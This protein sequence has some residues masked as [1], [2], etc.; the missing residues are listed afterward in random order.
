[1]P[2]HQLGGRGVSGTRHWLSPPLRGPVYSL[3][4]GSTPFL[5]RPVLTVW[6]AQVLHDNAFCKQ[7]PCKDWNARPKLTACVPAAAIL[8]FTGEL[9]WVLARLSRAGGP[10]GPGFRVPTNSAHTPALSRQG[11]PSLRGHLVEA[12]QEALVCSSRFPGWQPVSQQP[13]TKT[14]STSSSREGQTLLWSSSG[15]AGRWPLLAARS[16]PRADLGEGGIPQ[17]T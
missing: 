7:S 3:A 11:A 6:V 15:S 4:G 1:M 5:C 10:Q 2:Q 13:E 16:W 8:G 14:S 17:V 9:L 12:V